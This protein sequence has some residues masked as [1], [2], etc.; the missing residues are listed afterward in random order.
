MYDKSNVHYVIDVALTT[1]YLNRLSSY[2]LGSDILLKIRL[3]TNAN[4]VWERAYFH[5]F[6]SAFTIKNAAAPCPPPTY[7]LMDLMLKGPRQAKIK[8]LISRFLKNH[9]NLTM[10]R[11]VRLGSSETILTMAKI[12][13]ACIVPSVLEHWR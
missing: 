9:Y 6:A 5:S 12:K 8:S 4:G 11:S 7:C 13:H 1:I 10:T 2:Q 3:S